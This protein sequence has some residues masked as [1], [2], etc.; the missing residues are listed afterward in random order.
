MV[1]LAT[2]AATFGDRLHSAGI[3]VTPGAIRAIRR[4]DRSHRAGDLRRHLLGGTNH[5]GQRA[6]PD[7]AV[8]PSVRS[9]VRRARRSGRHP[10]RPGR[11]AGQ[12]QAAAARRLRAPT[13]RRGAAGA[14]R[15]GEDHD[16]GDD[17]VDGRDAGDDGEQ[18][19]IPA[20]GGLR[21]ADADGAD[22]PALTD[23]ADA[24]RSAEAHPTAHAAII[25]EVGDSTCGQRSAEASA[26][27]AIRSSGSDADRQCDHDAW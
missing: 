12:Q 3:P 4:G 21:R 1:D 14:G 27:R 5:T 11:S 13:A 8:R 6:R 7:R 24:P 16:H 20:L 18:R 10:R 25:A 15:S 22:E 26:P 9:R 23:G 19:R 17:E 2:V